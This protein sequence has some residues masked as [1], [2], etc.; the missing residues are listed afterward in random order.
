MK[1]KQI[2]AG[3]LTAAMVLTCT[4][5]SSL[6]AEGQGMVSRAVVDTSV[7]DEVTYTDIDLTDESSYTITDVST[8]NEMSGFTLTVVGKYTGGASDTS[9]FAL[10]SLMD[11]NNNYL[12]V[13]YAP[14]DGTV[15][16][17]YS[18]AGTKS[19]NGLL[20]SGN[21]GAVAPGKNFKVSFSFATIGGNPY[22]YASVNGAC[23]KTNLPC[24]S[25]AFF[26]QFFTSHSWTATKALI[27]KA[28]VNNH[29][30][31]NRDN[32][33]DFI[34]TIDRVTVSNSS[35]T[36]TADAAAKTEIIGLN[37]TPIAAY[38][39][40]LNEVI[41][42]CNYQEDQCTQ[43]TWSAY[44]S[45][46]TAADTVAANE[47]AYD[48]DVLNAMDT[49]V[50]A[51]ENLLE[52]GKLKDRMNA[53]I[54]KAQAHL[55]LGTESFVSGYEEL[56]S[57]KTTAEGVN[58]DEIGIEDF[59]A[60]VESLE[61]AIDNLVF[62][63][64]VYTN[65]AVGKDIYDVEDALFYSNM[66]SLTYTVV[67]KYNAASSVEF[68]PLVTLR[69]DNGKYVTIY[70]GVVTNSTNGRD[71]RVAFSYQGSGANAFTANPVKIDDTQYHKLTFSFKGKDIN[72][73]LDGGSVGS[74][75]T[76]NDDAV[77]GSRWSQ[78][79]I[80]T[81]N[82]N[83]WTHVEIGKQYTNDIW[84]SKANYVSDFPDA[85]IKYV[86]ISRN[87]NDANGVATVND[88]TNDGI[89]QERDALVAEKA[90]TISN[91]VSTYYTSD[92]WTAYETAC[93]NASAATTDWDIMNKIDALKT[94][95]DGLTK[96]SPQFSGYSI[97]LGGKIGVKFYTEVAEDDA[98]K[99]PV[100]T[101]GS[102]ELTSVQTVEN[103]KKVYTVELPAKKM[104][105]D[106]T[107]DMMNVSANECL[108]R[109]V[110][111]VADYA[112]TLLAD[113]TQSDELKALVKAMLNYGA[114]AQVQF[115][116]NTENPANASLND[117]DKAVAEIGTE[118]DADCGRMGV[119]AD[120]YK[121]LSLVLNSET[122][123]K[124]YATT[125]ASIVLKKDGVQVAASGSE[126]N[127][128]FS[129]VTLANIA[130]N[131]LQDTYTVEIGGTEVG[132]V[133]PLLYCY[134]VTKGSFDA[135]LKNLV[136]ALYQYNKAAVAYNTSSSSNQ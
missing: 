67:F 17:A 132:T 75:K 125:D 92:S 2:L 28:P 110:C 82:A 73:Q 63:D 116:Y 111:S 50:T 6:A 91:G 85:T 131:H 9:P 106:I 56:E 98:T 20:W 8:F 95:K 70:F 121:G 53:A 65:V 42:G 112:D 16:Y 27:G 59:P 124:L 89:V 34:G 136:N 22:L 120:G 48:W 13:W 93:T 99:A 68:A 12:T 78:D 115:S 18:N 52:R 41:A 77:A 123:L 107:V 83:A 37:T 19:G 14:Q 54:S 66:D 47:S 21:A 33:E 49:L 109:V 23:A 69:D 87:A 119:T 129:Y 104:A 61:S 102:S 103:G 26:P 3:V 29:P 126:K 51:C 7:T 127:N 114:A 100:F 58:T 96:T 60:A 128:G 10:F 130:A 72:M 11:E 74:A 64:K 86:Q 135:S 134:N 133:S 113:D 1:M 94:A 108:D 32:I 55:D 43:A 101:S 25:F 90:D 44:T 31:K 117:T 36:S 45:A 76:I 4:P 118:L 62:V 57:A 88:S 105:D 71:G 35:L 97:T 79:F 24:S 39:E 80:G 46:K 15:C 5:V 84:A 81:L 122:A 30:I 38:K 40:K